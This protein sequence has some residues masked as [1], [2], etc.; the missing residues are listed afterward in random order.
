MKKLD[1]KASIKCIKEQRDA[2]KKPY[3]WDNVL[4]W[5]EKGLEVEYDSN[6]RPH[7]FTCGTK[8]EVIDEITVK[9]KF[10]KPIDMQSHC[11]FEEALVHNMLI[12][13]V[14]ELQGYWENVD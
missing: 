2:Q 13:T 6:Q 1:I 3:P 11:D 14:D 8:G 7:T 10:N 5:A 9:I 4:D 12:G